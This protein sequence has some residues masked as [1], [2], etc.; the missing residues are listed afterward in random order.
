MFKK[1]IIDGQ[2]TN[3]SV[4]D[5]G[6]FRNDKTGKFI[7]IGNSGGVQMTVN[8][9]PITKM[10]ARLFA[11][12]F[13]PNPENKKLVTTFNGDPKDLRVENIRWIT[14]KENSQLTWEKRRKNGTTGAGQVR[15]KRKRENIVE[16]IDSAIEF[17]FCITRLYNYHATGIITLSHLTSCDSA[18]S[19]TS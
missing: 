9:K 16:G 11:E 13:V 19:Q 5:K 4:S 2:E 1:I 14:D 12:A 7:T 8:G 6:E 3:Y 17:D 15:G 10:A 18:K